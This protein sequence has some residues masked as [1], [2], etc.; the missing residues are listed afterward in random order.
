METIVFNI[1]LGLCIFLALFAIAGCIVSYSASPRTSKAFDN[2]FPII[3]VLTLF[4]I[5]IAVIVYCVIIVLKLI[6]N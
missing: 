6:I 1:M 4:L 5:F 3:W 2:M